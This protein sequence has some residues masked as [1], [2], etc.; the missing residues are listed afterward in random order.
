MNNY[1]TYGERGC[2]V[3]AA[4]TVKFAVKFRNIFSSNRMRGIFVEVF[5][6]FLFVNTE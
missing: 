4:K 2:F 5:K 6:R 1:A 3:K